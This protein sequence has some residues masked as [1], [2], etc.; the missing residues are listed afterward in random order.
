MVNTKYLGAAALA[1]VAGQLLVGC[2]ST[3]R[4]AREEARIAENVRAVIDR[5]P[6]VDPPNQIDVQVNDHWVYL[7]G[8]AN[9][10]LSIADVEAQVRK[11]RGVVGVT[12][13]I[14]VED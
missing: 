5:L 6:V 14:S 11:V 3:S 10:E 12:N 13:S 8:S 2:A 7:T 9:T 1:V 4:D